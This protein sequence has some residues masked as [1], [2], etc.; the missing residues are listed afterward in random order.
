MDSPL[1]PQSPV[2]SDSQVSVVVP[3]LAIMVVI[4]TLV[5]GVLLVTNSQ[6]QRTQSQVTESSEQ[7]NSYVQ[8][9]FDINGTLPQ[10]ASVDLIATK[11]DGT[12]VTFATDINPQ[13]TDSWNF[14]EAKAREAYT[15][16]AVV[17]QNGKEL[18]RS[19][20]IT[21][22]A[23]ADDEV[24][25]LNVES[26]SS[27]PAVITTDVVVNGFIPQGATLTLQARTLGA[28]QF[29]VVAAGLVGLTRQSVS[30]ASAVSGKTYEI[31]AILFAADGKTLIGTSHVLPVTAPA[32]H[33]LLTINSS[34][35]AQAAPQTQAIPASTP[36]PVANAVI[37][38]KIDFN[39]IAPPNSRI[40][41]LQKV[42]NTQN[43]QVAIDNI[44]AQD[45]QT[46]TWKNPAP[47]TWYD[48]VAVLKQK[49][50]DGSDKD[51]STSSMA[52]VAAPATGV[53]FTLNSSF[54]LNA[55]N[56]TVN[57]DCGTKS[58]NTW[59]ATM[60]F[61]PQSGAGSYWYQV[62]TTSG[63][64]DTTST[65]VNANGTN[66]LV[67]QV[68][69]QNGV[70]YYLQYAYAIESNVGAGSKQFSPFSQPHQ[71]QCGN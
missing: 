34:A 58:G 3:I 13:D 17:R 29:S 64:A 66:P 38:G 31:Q 23:P 11:A 14:A 30:Y 46:W 70:K 25:R 44:Q 57:T 9:H 47:S 27:Q 8:G 52:S 20:N 4:L 18:L 22:T 56:G 68:G 32:S 26:I 36:A 41:I 43:Y 39:G 35:Q 63:G 40:V 6:N 21:V 5:S 12:S 45:G 55:P 49:Q 28:S 59:P 69:L 15:I 48:L 54:G 16:Q 71:I 61:S 2:H 37:S 24:L 62:G 60:T 7:T 65:A 10:G 19:G 67:A 42:Y 53:T 51:L 50:S 1:P 33:E